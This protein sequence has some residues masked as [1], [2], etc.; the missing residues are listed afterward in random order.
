MV[1]AY[2]EDGSYRATLTNKAGRC[3][4]LCRRG[5]GC[6]PL[7]DCRYPSRGTETPRDVERGVQKGMYY[8]LDGPDLS[9]CASVFAPEGTP[10]AWELA[11]Q[12]GEAN[13]LPF[14]FALVK[15]TVGKKGLQQTSDLSGLKHLWLDYLPNSLVWPLCSQRMMAIIAEHLTGNEGIDWIGAKVNGAGEQREYFVL[16]F[17]KM[18][19]VLNMQ[20]TIFV[21]GSDYVRSPCFTAEVFRSIASSTF[22]MNTGYGESRT[23][24]YVSAALKSSH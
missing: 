24:F 17:T 6:H 23:S 11:L 19:D 16:R 12:V 3:H 1:T 2:L 22:R 20:N 7:D 18:L 5:L 8:R 13:E 4:R 21:P 9:S 14:A 10:V 15:L